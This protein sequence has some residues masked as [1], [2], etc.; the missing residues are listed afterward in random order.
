MED[1]DLSTSGSS[2][3][4]VP[5][6]K[7]VMNPEDE[8][9]Y[10]YLYNLSNEKEEFEVDID[11]TFTTILKQLIK[12]KQLDMTPG[13]IV[14]IKNGIVIKKSDSIEDYFHSEIL[15]IP[16]YE[17]TMRPRL[18]I[19]PPQNNL[20]NRVNIFNSNL[21]DNLINALLHP[22]H[23]E[24]T[25]HTHLGNIIGQ[26]AS[27]MNIINNYI[28]ISDT[29]NPIGSSMI[30]EQQIN[31]NNENEEKLDEDIDDNDEYHHPEVYINLDND[32]NEDD[33]NDDEE[34]NQE[35]YNENNQEED[36]N[37]EN[38][39]EQQPLLNQDDILDI[40]DDLPY[41]DQENIDM[42]TNMGY[43]KED[44]IQ[45]YMIANKSVE[46]TLLLLSG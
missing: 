34:H 27:Q 3:L 30:R 42:I 21:T 24:L 18:V 15:Y 41:E 36:Y 23:I 32:V 44:V 31:N 26:F 28:N 2:L 16:M 29:L 4:S 12:K 9:K 14:L 45:L 35:E 5:V 13:D 37:E 10:I 7:I 8:I 39:E 22:P 40:F 33:N 17:S 19:P 1:K 20:E 6:H 46:E 25:Q 38:V 11:C 43:Q